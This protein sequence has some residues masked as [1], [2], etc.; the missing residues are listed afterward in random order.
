MNG[1]SS[2]LKI[3]GEG[4]SSSSD[5]VEQ[6]LLL[7]VVK[8]NV[9]EVWIVL[10]LGNDKGLSGVVLLAGGVGVEAGGVG[11]LKLDGSWFSNLTSDFIW[12]FLDELRFWY[13]WFISRGIWTKKLGS[14]WRGAVSEELPAAPLLSVNSVS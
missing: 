12:L 11:V 8:N 10:M 7:L 3:L 13:C 5:V 6:L 2:H 14:L 1:H 4:F 9:D